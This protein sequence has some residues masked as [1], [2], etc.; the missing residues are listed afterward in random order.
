MV[1]AQGE[2]RQEV[3]E[4]GGVGGWVAGGRAGTLGSVAGWRWGGGGGKSNDRKVSSKPVEVSRE[5]CTV[6][7]LRI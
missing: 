2:G 1:G 5:L 7:W 6:P 3:D 4:G